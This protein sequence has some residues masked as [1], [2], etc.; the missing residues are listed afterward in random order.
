VQGA[1]VAAL[2]AE[3]VR[4]EA[5][6]FGELKALPVAQLLVFL[7]GAGND[8]TDLLLALLT[9]LEDDLE[10]AQVAAMNEAMDGSDMPV[11]WSTLLRSILARAR[12]A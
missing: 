1:E 7:C 6:D 12:R 3:R 9:G 2:A 5:S 4:L 11:D 8:E 10:R